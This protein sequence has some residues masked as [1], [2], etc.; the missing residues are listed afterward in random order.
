LYHAMV[1]R[2]VR[3]AFDDLSRG[4]YGTVVQISHRNVHHVFAGDHPLGGER[5]SRDAVK[6]WFERLFRLF[7][8][9]RFEVRDVLVKG[10][11]WN[12]KVA[13]AWVAQVTPLVGEPY[14]NEGVH[15]IQFRWGRL[16]YFH[17]YEDSQ[18]VADACRR[19]AAEG[20]EEAA[21]A[22]ISE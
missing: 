7:P 6:E 2:K 13:V 18:K 12:T 22:P 15:L 16:M 11:P 5:H 19:M 4:N 21:A 9:L 3:S 8:Q 14:A 10:W 17:A 1:Q 20:I